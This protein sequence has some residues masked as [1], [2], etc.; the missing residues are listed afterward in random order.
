MIEKQEKPKGVGKKLLILFILMIVTFQFIQ[1]NRTNPIFNP[2]DEI[3]APKHVI[4]ILKKACY[5]CHS[6]ETIW[7][8]YSKIAPFSWSIVQ[9][10]NNGRAYV[11]FSIWNSYTKKQ[12]NKKLSDI[13]RTIYAVMPP[14]SYVKIHKKAI[15]TKKE[16]TL[17]RNWT[18]KSPYE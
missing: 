7:P 11:N 18:G 2:A 13:Y 1:V 3:K 16:R 12:K 17:I 8:W 9:H 6:N 14:Q 4:T 5:D 10:V 15:L